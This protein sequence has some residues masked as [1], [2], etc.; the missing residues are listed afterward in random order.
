MKHLLTIAGSDSC[1]G[2]G[3]QADLKTFSALGT[4]GMSVINAITAQ[5]TQGVQEVYN[6][7]VGI[8]RSQLDS[9]LSDITVDAVKIGMLSSVEIIETVTERLSHYQPPNIVLDPVMVS[10]NGCRLLEEDA[11]GALAR[12]MLPLC[13]IVTPNIPEAEVL[14]GMKIVTSADIE[15][16]L[17]RIYSMGAK[18]VL[19]KGGHLPGDATDYLF[20]GCRIHTFPVAR[21][22]TKNTHGTGCTL[23]SAIAAF[24]AC[25]LSAEAAVA[26]AK[27][28]V[29]AAI[30]HALT[31]GS[32]IGPTNHF[33][34]LY[35]KAGL[36]TDL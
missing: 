16:A 23:S 21:I 26:N 27:E 29:T 14:T 35:Q 33:Y 8:V 22:Q 5:N 6:L 13:D 2:A 19:I 7:P 12:N 1:G 10:K 36:N 15:A 24:L 28:Y 3:I 4:Y 18:R 25:G 32:G 11:S 31:I 30:E 20:D 17:G 9:V 34:S